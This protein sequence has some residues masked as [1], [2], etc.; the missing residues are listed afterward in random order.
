MALCHSC[1]HILRYGNDN[2]THTTCRSF[3]A[4]VDQGCY[5]EE[6][7]ECYSRND[8]LEYGD[9]GTI[10]DNCRLFLA[11]VDRGCYICQGLFRQAP[12]EW[13]QEIRRRIEVFE[14]SPEKRRKADDSKKRLKSYK[15]EFDNSRYVKIWLNLETIDLNRGALPHGAELPRN[16]IQIVYP[17]AAESPPWTFTSLSTNSE[18]TFTKIK[19]WIGRCE[20]KHG[21]CQTRRDKADVGW[22]PTR[23]IEI[24]SEPK[25]GESADSLKYRIVEPKSENMPQNLRYITLSHRWPQDKQAFQKLTV[26]NLPL[27]KASL[28]AKI[29]RQT[30]R[31]A[32]FV[33]Q[34]LE[35]S[36]VWIDSLCI[37]QHG[38]GGVD[39]TK[40]S[41]QMHKVYSNAEFNLCASKNDKDEGLFSPRIPSRPQPLR[42]KL[43]RLEDD[44]RDDYDDGVEDH[45]SGHYLIRTE[46]SFDTWN[47]RMD[48]SPLESRGWVFQEQL[49][50]R[51]NLHFCDHEVLFECLEMR[52]SESLGS[53]L[54]YEVHW[55]YDH[56]FFKE[57]LPTSSSDESSVSSSNYEEYYDDYQRWH[58]LLSKYTARQLTIPDDRL[59]ALSGVAQYFK[60]I[61]PHGDCYLAGLWWSRIHTEM[62]WQLKE[63]TSRENW[64]ERKARRHLTFSWAS[65]QGEVENEA[66][67]YHIGEPLERLADLEPIKYRMS[68]DAMDATGEGERFVEEIFSLPSSPAIEIRIT[69][70]LRPMRL[71][72]VD[73]STRWNMWP[74]MKGRTFADLDL[75]L[76]VRGRQQSLSRTALTRLDF[77]ISSS[78][79]T[80]LNTSGRL[81]L[82]PLVGREGSSV[83][84]LLLELVKTSDGKDMGRFRRIGVFME[85]HFRSVRK[86]LTHKMPFEDSLS[87][88]PCWR[89]DDVSK[90]HTIFVV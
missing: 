53:N 7:K 85:Q 36:Y 49:L 18:E 77:E 29:L 1:D 4:A 42:F 47:A 28:P 73:I 86:W 69:G 45:D 11:G 22:H 15:R 23:L 9:D 43:P 52:A 89:Y 81:F 59:I 48:D 38:D 33:A 83:W 37:I 3:L 13:K 82:M 55:R 65:V 17:V 78:E 34:R 32:L 35:I 71:E 19:S 64:E 41:P 90:R 67:T 2:I 58:D 6:W 66:D 27:W 46:E 84:I 25:N 80:A 87:E 72:R 61:F 31:D 14:S 51:A 62:L 60:T 39:W 70:L 8:I 5:P 68:S 54:D 56:R 76:Y 21:E 79:L 10:H 30:F 40:E 50:S 20:K 88:L 26:D 44:D 74:E 75:L 63:A 57:H 12:E 16:P 24:V